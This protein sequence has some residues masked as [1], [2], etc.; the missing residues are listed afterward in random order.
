MRKFAT[1]GAAALLVISSAVGISYAQ[2]S[3]P[4][5]SATDT[6]APPLQMQRTWLGV[7]VSDT[8]TGVSIVRVS[9]N[10]PAETAQLQVD[11]LI[12]AVNGSA[13]TSASDLQAVVDAAASGDVITLTIERAG[14]QMSVEVTLGSRDGRGGFAPLSDP[15]Q[16]TEMMLNVQL[17]GIETGYQVV[18]VGDNATFDLAVGDVITAVN[19]EAI[20]SVDWMT[21]MTPGSDNTVTL[22][23]E[24]DGAEITLDG[25]IGFFGGR[26]GFPGGGFPGGGQPNGMPNGGP[27]PR[28]NNGGNGQPNGIPNNQAPAAPNGGQPPS[29]VGTTV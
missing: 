22:T 29:D 24:R 13:I 4:V 3:T 14:E 11:D 10:S 27:G 25:Q 5:P 18:E 17:E 23:V 1:Y 19:D 26:G 21:L 8:D 12:T 28:G 6:A 7:S 15:L 2:D 20:S 9:R 16:A